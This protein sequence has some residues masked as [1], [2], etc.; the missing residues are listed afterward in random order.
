[1]SATVQI[2]GLTKVYGKLVAVNHVSYDIME[3]EIFGLLGPNGCGKTTTLLMLLGLISPTE[4]TAT[5]NGADVVKDPIGARRSVGLLTDNVGLYENLT[6]RQNLAF[7]A[8]LSDLPP[9]EASKRVDELLGLVGLADKRDVR[10][11]TMSRGMRQ[12]LGVAQ[13]LVRDPKV[14]VLD[15]P[16][17]GIDPEGTKEL[18]GIIKMLSRERGKTIIFTSHLLSEVNRLCDR[19]AIMKEGKVIAIGTIPE[20]RRQINAAEGDEFEEVFL[21]YQGV[22]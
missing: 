12:R 11:S 13:S 2:S 7:F 5:I 21:R 9:S 22:A 20:L 6:A 4:G 18:R 10:V 16:T 8:E 19:V 17:L 15:E 1:M 14:L 3:G